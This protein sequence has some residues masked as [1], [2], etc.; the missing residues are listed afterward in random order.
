L[1]S[2]AIPL[3]RPDGARGRNP[4][5]SALLRRG[6]EPDQRG[7]VGESNESTTFELVVNAQTARMLGLAIPPT[8]LVPVDGAEALTLLNRM[9]WRD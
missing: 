3:Y 5:R 1:V 9:T 4:V 8:L 6:V 7:H 2:F